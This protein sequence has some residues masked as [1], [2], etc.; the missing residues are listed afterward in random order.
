[1]AWRPWPVTAEPACLDDGELTAATAAAAVARAHGTTLAEALGWYAA[2]GQLV[3]AAPTI[4]EC[5]CAYLEEKRA[6]SRRSATLKNYRIVLTRLAVRFAGRPLTAITPEEIRRYLKQWPNPNTL[7]TIWR[8]LFTFF[9]RAVAHGWVPENPL[10]RAIP[11]PRRQHREGDYYSPR[12][13]AWILRQ[14]KGTDQLGFWVLALFAGMRTTEIRRLQAQPSPWTMIRLE[15]GVID[16]PA[17]VSKTRPR[18][19]P[20]SPVLQAW[21]EDLQRY[22]FPLYPRDGEKKLSRTRRLL[23]QAGRT[24]A[25]SP[26][27]ARRSYISYQLV[28]PGASYAKV[29]AAAGNSEQTIRQF[30]RSRVT[31]EAARAYFALGPEQIK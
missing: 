10:L 23:T 22:Q 19:V 18:I 29:A 21:L 6:A 17:A 13:A 16:I 30:Y 20:I 8:E 28:L 25:F 31:R 27:L 1:M 14:V 7:C 12:D 24:A 15:S 5:V 9:N 4:D 3:Q 2:R 26:N 11:R